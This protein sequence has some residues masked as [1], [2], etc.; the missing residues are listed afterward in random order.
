[1][2]AASM[3]TL[4]A[5]VAKLVVEGCCNSAHSASEYTQGTVRSSNEG[6]RSKYCLQKG[7]V[8]CRAAH[9]THAVI[10]CILLCTSARMKRS[11]SAGIWPWCS[12]HAVWCSSSSELRPSWPTTMQCSRRI[13]MI[14]SPE[15][16]VSTANTPT[17]CPP[18]P[19]ESSTFSVLAPTIRAHSFISTL[20]AISI[21]WVFFSSPPS[22]SLSHTRGASPARIQ[23]RAPSGPTDCACHATAPESGSR[24][25]K[26]SCSRDQDL[27]R[28]PSGGVC[29][30]S[31]VWWLT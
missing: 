6:T 20:G 23:W 4:S 13:S 26:S 28:H 12:C 17:P 9:N 18:P 7:E 24:A 3:R 21:G 8:Q 5:S 30:I 1:M 16:M 29:R 11:R 31:C 25:I 19:A 27:T 15:A 2:P 14:V 10:R 22:P